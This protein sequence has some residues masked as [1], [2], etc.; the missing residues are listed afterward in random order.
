MTRTG[1]RIKRTSLKGRVV[2][3][4]NFGRLR[5]QADWNRSM[6]MALYRKRERVALKALSRELKKQTRIETGGFPGVG[7]APGTDVFGPIEEEPEEE[8]EDDWGEAE[9]GDDY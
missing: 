1:Q 2:F 5:N 6:K 8:L 4:D 9:G 7:R 3:R